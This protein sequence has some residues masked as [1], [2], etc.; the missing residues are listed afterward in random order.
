MRRNQKKFWLLMRNYSAI[1]AIIMFALAIVSAQTDV[2]LTRLPVGDGYLSTAPQVGYIWS[3]Q[4]NFNPDAAGAHA[5][6]DWI[7]G[8]G[9]FDFT[10]KAV[11]DGDVAWDGQLDI[12]IVGEERILTGNGLPIYHTTGVYPVSS[13]DDA[14]QIDRNPNQINSQD[15]AWVLPTNP[16]FADS[17]S[18]VPMGAVGVM[19][20]GAVVFNALDG[21]GRDAVA[22][23]T[24]DHCQGH[25]ERTGEY[26]YHNLS[27]CV[28]AYEETEGGHSALMG[29]ALDGF[30]IYGHHGE[31][32]ETITTTDLDECHGHTHLVE[33][34]GAMVELY[35]YHATYEYPYTISC[36]RGTPLVSA[37]AGP[38]PQD[39]ND[40]RSPQ[41]GNGGRPPQGG[42]G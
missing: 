14:Y 3:C 39:G 4:T 26:H 37:M 34:D 10:A 36:F 19:L 30:G 40:G 18:C 5:I 12:T 27:D 38:P 22:Y 23:E 15:N 24:L 29:Y 20:S 33:W 32:G 21:G 8:D 25:P 17:P 42:G 35:H 7:H 16:T 2:D 1:G 9:T 31:N 28:E 41:G 11:V 6:G 13:N